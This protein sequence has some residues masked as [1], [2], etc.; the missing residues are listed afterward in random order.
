MFIYKY[1]SANALKGIIESNRIGFTEPP[2]FNDPFDQPRVIRTSYP[3]D[4]ISMFDGPQTADQLADADDK[5]WNRCGVA[6]FTRTYDNSLM[7][8]HYADS[9]KGAVIE[10]DAEKA[11]LM[12]SSLL[13]PVQFG[14]VIYMKR[15]NRKQPKSYPFIPESGEGRFDIGNFELL[16][17]LFL[18]KPIAWAYEEEVRAVTDIYRTLDN[19]GQMPW[20]DLWARITGTG[21]VVYGMALAPQS[22]TRVFCGKNYDYISWLREQGVSRSFHVLRS[23]LYPD[24]FGMTF[25]PFD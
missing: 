10:I 17:R 9:H 18:S 12:S 16:Q 14:S 13:I 15:P 22:I 23:V 11:G 7:W 6:S 8:S 2:Y 1:V 19:F 21:K 3:N 20:D 5:H 25:E 4:H 24:E